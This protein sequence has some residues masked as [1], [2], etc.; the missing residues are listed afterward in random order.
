MLWAIHL[1][2]SCP[3]AEVLTGV[4]LN[5]HGNALTLSRPL[6]EAIADPADL[7]RIAR[8]RRRHRPLTFGVVF[9]YSS[10]HLLMRSWLTAAGL[11]PERDVRVVVVPPAQM[12][13]NLS[14]GTIDGFCAGEPWNSVAIQSGVGS[15]RL[16]SAR[17]QPG[18]AEKVLLVRQEFAT[19]HAAE[20]AALIA[21]VTEAAAWC[22]RPD[23]RPALA[24]LLSQPRYLNQS[25]AVI[26]PAL[27]GAFD[28]G[29]GTTELV[30]DFLV[31]HADDANLPSLAKANAVQAALVDAGLLAPGAATPELPGKL[32]R[33]DLHAAARA[34]SSGATTPLQLG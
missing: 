13:R 24:E 19:R 22:D 23:N 1:G 6:A 14:A 26:A 4:V 28:P 31:F 34:D 27:L 20:H 32:F 9:P 2:L 12:S 30:P 16:I 8:E 21:A 17:A 5:L 11:Q 18:L 29:T 15:C 7:R 25:R 3:A 33:A 10:H